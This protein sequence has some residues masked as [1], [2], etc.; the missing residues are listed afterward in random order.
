MSRGGKNELSGNWKRRVFGKRFEQLS[1]KRKDRQ[2]WRSD[3]ASWLMHEKFLGF[4]ENRYVW[5][6]ND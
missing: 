3:M 4:L 6:Q 5:R 1:I 2:D